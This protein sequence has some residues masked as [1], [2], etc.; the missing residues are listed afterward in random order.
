M[1][2]LHPSVWTSKGVLYTHRWFLAY[3]VPTYVVT[4]KWRRRC[5]TVKQFASVNNCVPGCVEQERIVRVCVL[6]SNLYRIAMRHTKL[7]TYGTVAFQSVHLPASILMACFSRWTLDRWS[8]SVFILHLFQ[9]RTFW[10]KL[11]C[12]PNDVPVTIQQCQKTEEITSTDANQ[13]LPSSF[14]HTLLDSL[15]AYEFNHF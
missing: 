13:W 8:P 11:L 4:A 5:H 1:P 7:P 14:L 12:R 6:Y 9:N 10:D 15:H 3:A 2:Q